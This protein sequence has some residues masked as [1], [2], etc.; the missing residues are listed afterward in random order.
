MCLH[1]LLEEEHDMN[2]DEILRKML[3]AE[4]E[5]NTSR[6]RAVTFA[7]ALTLQAIVVILGSLLIE[8]LNK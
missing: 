8:F 5:H 6:A 4:F 2:E 3:V 7:M 1:G